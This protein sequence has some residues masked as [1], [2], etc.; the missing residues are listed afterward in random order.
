M[1]EETGHTINIAPDQRGQLIILEQF[2]TQIIEDVKTRRR[3]DDAA[4]LSSIVDLAFTLGYNA[5]RDSLD[6]A[7]ELRDRAVDRVEALGE[8]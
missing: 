2:A 8:R 5:P 4:L 7:V 6:K 3:K 1:T